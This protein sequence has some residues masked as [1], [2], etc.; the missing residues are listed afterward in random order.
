MIQF[1]LS[2]VWFLYHIQTKLSKELAINFFPMMDIAGLALR[3]PYK[4]HV[5]APV[6]DAKFCMIKNLLNNHLS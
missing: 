3:L 1:Y 5:Q 6:N 4:C 2:L